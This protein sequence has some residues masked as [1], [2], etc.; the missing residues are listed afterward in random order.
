MKKLLSIL[1]I[2]G[3]VL[4]NTA[5]ACCT[6]S[7]SYGYETRTLTINNASDNDLMRIKLHVPNYLGTINETITTTEGSGEVEIIVVYLPDDMWDEGCYYSAVTGT[8]KSFE[9]RVFPISDSLIQWKEFYSYDFLPLFSGAYS[10]DNTTLQMHLLEGPGLYTAMASFYYTEFDTGIEDPETIY[11]AAPDLL[12]VSAA[13]IPFLLVL[14]DQT[15]GYFLE[16]G[17]LNSYGKYEW[18]GLKELLLSNLPEAAAGLAN[19]KTRRHYFSGIFLDIAGTGSV[20]PQWYDN[21]ALQAYEL[22]LMEGSAGKFNPQGNITLAQALAMACRMHN[23]YA[24][25]SGDFTE[26]PVWYSIYVNYAL[27][28]GII[29][30]DDF[31]AASEGESVYSRK[32]TR[33]EMAYIFCNALP[34][35]ALEQINT[36]NRIPDVT[37]ATPYDDEIFTLYR[38]GILDGSDSFHSFMPD[39]NITRAQA[40]AIICRLADPDQRIEFTI[41]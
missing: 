18:P 22:G 34:E 5:A 12:N 31:G 7:F 38:A 17:T 11:Q 16:H 15:I 10:V 25:G 36:I 1:L 24:G 27:S 2:C 29:K 30:A 41:R 6:D 26:G 20:R 35:A 3:L 37:A 9:A 4:G 28:N 13:G 21:Y 8:I 33:G 23:I 39:S 32:A 19:F 14:D 40:A